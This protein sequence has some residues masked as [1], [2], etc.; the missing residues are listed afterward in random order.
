MGGSQPKPIE[1]QIGKAIAGVICVA[2]VVM[3]L[4]GYVIR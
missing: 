2:I 4:W 1:D 3:F